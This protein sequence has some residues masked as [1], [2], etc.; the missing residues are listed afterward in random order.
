MP[1]QIL[2][3]RSLVWWSDWLITSWSQVQILPG[4]SLAISKRFQSI[5]LEKMKSVCVTQNDHCLIKHLRFSPDHVLN[6]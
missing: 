3:A 1:Y 4:P 5:A 2:R 6:P